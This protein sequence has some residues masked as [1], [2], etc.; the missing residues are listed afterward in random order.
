MGVQ[1]S[2]S[3]GETESAQVLLL[4][5]YSAIMNT[6]QLLI[7]LLGIGSSGKSTL[8]KQLQIKYRNGFTEE[9]KKEY[10][11]AINKNAFTLLHRSLYL[12]TNI[13]SNAISL[14]YSINS[15]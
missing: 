1:T 13:N 5:M 3:R 12:I 4:G 14:D 8:R 6:L 15:V 2:K 10:V 9:E 11:Q 7:H